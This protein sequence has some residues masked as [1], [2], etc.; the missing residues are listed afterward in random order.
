LEDLG[1]PDGFGPEN[2]VY[3]PNKIAIKSRDNDQQNH[4][5]NG[6]HHFQTNPGKSSPLFHHFLCIAVI[7]EADDRF[8]DHPFV[9]LVHRQITWLREL[10]DSK[11]D[12]WQLPT[13]VHH[14]DEHVIN[15]L[16]IDYSVVIPS[17]ILTERCLG[18]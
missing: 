18:V 14:V 3:S 10:Y 5:V 12:Q 2:G 1:N 8:K 17:N 7:L 16:F 13:I 6:V 4:W 15:M 9:A 11:A